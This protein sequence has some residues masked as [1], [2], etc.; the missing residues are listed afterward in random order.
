MF[1]TDLIASK[2][3]IDKNSAKNLSQR[4]SVTAVAAASDLTVVLVTSEET[5]LGLNETQHPDEFVTDDLLSRISAENPDV[6][7]SSSTT[8]NSLINA[9]SSEVVSAALQVSSLE[10]VAA[11]REALGLNTSDIHHAKEEILESL[12]DSEVAESLKLID[13]IQLSAPVIVEKDQQTSFELIPDSVQVQAETHLVTVILE[14]LPDTEVE[15][16]ED[17]EFLQAAVVE[18]SSAVSV[19]S[20]PLYVVPD[21]IARVVSTS[22]VS[23]SVV[24][25]QLVETTVMLLKNG[26]AYTNLTKPPGELE[27]PS[28]LDNADAR[29]TTW[30]QDDSGVIYLASRG[31]EHESILAGEE[32]DLKLMSTE[33]I[34][35]LHTKTTA[36]TYGATMMTTWSD[37]KFNL[38]GTFEKT[39]SMLTTTGGVGTSLLE[40]FSSTFSQD[41]P[42]S[43]SNTFSGNSELS[44]PGDVISINTMSEVEQ[45][46]TH[47]YGNFIVLGDGLSIEMQYANGTVSRELLYRSKN[48]VHFGA[49]S[50]QT[51]TQPE[52]YLERMQS[53]LESRDEDMR[54]LWLSLLA[55]SVS[56]AAKEMAA[57][58]PSRTTSVPGQTSSTEM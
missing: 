20:G 35:G 15:N 49:A 33:D 24:G 47:L 7:E 28:E 21:L 6:A 29:W 48:Y 18:A 5:L 41:S 58:N 9:S 16:I 55:D 56:A 1:T 39:K 23:L 10:L 14:D 57:T 3:A 12:S 45:P 8:T 26:L 4:N 11:G 44:E 31:S 17:P 19:D 46:N 53:L 52:H 40:S 32:I 30:R 2:S 51:Q 54:G 42:H 22:S 25:I 34:A 38:D 36:E 37:I 13:E 27:L 50:Y 43:S